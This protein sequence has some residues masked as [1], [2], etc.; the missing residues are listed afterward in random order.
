MEETLE[1]GFAEV[2]TNQP[3]VSNKV[4]YIPHHSVLTPNKLRVVFDCSA[5]FNNVSLN[6]C[7]LQGP[8]LQNNLL[9]ILL[10]FRKDYVGI[11]CDVQKMYH[12]FKVEESDRDFL[13]FL[14]W[15]KGDTS[16][17]PVDHRMTVFLFGAT[18]S[19]GVATYGLRKIAISH[20][21][22]YS[23]EARNF[24][25]KNFYV[26]DG[27]ASVQSDEEAYQLL[28]NT[29][30][31]LSEGGL[32]LHKIMSNSKGLMKTISVDDRATV[33][34]VHKCKTLG[35]VWD[36]LSDELYIPLH[37]EVSICTRRGIL[38]AVSSIYDPMG[39][40][41]PLIL[42]AKL[43]LQTMCKNDCPWD[44]L[45]S[46]EL[47]LE[48]QRW[49]STLK[50]MDG[51]TISRCH[52]PSNEVVSV[53][54]HHFADASSIGYAA[55]SYVRYVDI[56][57]AISV[58]LMFGK[59]RVVPLKPVLT[60]P[61]L[62]LIAA[63]LSVQ[64]AKVLRK[65]LK[66][67]TKEYFWTDSSIVLGYIKSETL[68]FKVFVANRVQRIRAGSDPNQWFHVEGKQNP[69]DD[70]SR[71]VFTDRWLYGPQFLYH[72][73]EFDDKVNS[74][75]DQNDLEICHNINVEQIELSSKTFG[76][77][78]STKKLWAWVMRFI[79]NCRSGN[80]KATGEL[81]L[82]EIED[83]EVVIER[84]VQTEHFRE[85]INKIAQ[86][87]PVSSKSKL[88]KLNVFLDR[89]GLLR[90]GGRL[91]HGSLAYDVKH[92]VI[93]PETHDVTSL[94]ID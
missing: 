43:M 87:K 77:W 93:M 70:G 84:I 20:C 61:R 47:C 56:Y 92:P 46:S 31:L 29:K 69:A 49:C 72:D 48:F 15:P 73:I 39:I 27:V 41:A 42:K 26:D 9:S 34:S 24:V 50:E 67:T 54:L 52:K 55:C 68:T 8:D 21:S 17:T 11:T 30:G 36:T 16:L 65:E 75:I 63:T 88:Y 74:D 4:W 58:H 40:I 71:A 85:E 32:K 60:V 94:I 44:T 76:N 12:Q 19:P 22:K 1:S 64:L 82:R 80:V 23:I 13:R 66:L 79:N 18:S 7:L 25:L 10:R 38:S 28:V 6:E 5:K 78:F 37:V 53:E 89:Q 57:G 81:S 33:E 14:W 35:V 2:V 83:S 59:S 45:P 62:E 91:Q 86:N 3:H 90:V 51:V